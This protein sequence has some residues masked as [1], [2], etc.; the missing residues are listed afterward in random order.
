[1]LGCTLGLVVPGNPCT[2]DSC[3]FLCHDYFFFLFMTFLPVFFASR[4][5]AARPA[6]VYE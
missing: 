1:V 2:R 6:F 5:A 4:L 3:I